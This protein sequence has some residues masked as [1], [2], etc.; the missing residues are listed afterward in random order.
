MNVQMMA[1]V[2][3]L[4]TDFSRNEVEEMT[5]PELVFWYLIKD[6]AP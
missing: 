3:I 4:Y 2:V 6:P 1:D 5:Y